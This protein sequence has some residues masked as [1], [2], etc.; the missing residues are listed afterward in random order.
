MSR[1]TIALLPARGRGGPGAQ[2]KA[3]R[4]G[5]DKLRRPTPGHMRQ[6]GA[7]DARYLIALVRT[8]SLQLVCFLRISWMRNRAVAKV[9]VQRRTSTEKP[10]AT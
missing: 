3:C 7:N 6:A 10:H 1:K 5:Y 9:R 2:E 8:T 4:P